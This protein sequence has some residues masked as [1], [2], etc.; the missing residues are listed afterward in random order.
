MMESIEF[1]TLENEALSVRILPGL[2]GKITSLRLKENDFELAAPN[3]GGKYRQPQEDYGKED[4]AAARDGDTGPDFSRYDASGLDDAFPNIDACVTQW[5]GR[6]YCYP[7]HGEI[8]SHPFTVCETPE[9]PLLSW[10]SSRFGY[11]YEKRFSLSG[12]SLFIRYRIENRSEAAFPWLWTFHG[13]MRYEEDM[14]LLLPEDFERYRCVADHPVMGAAGS[15]LEAV[16]GRYDFTRVPKAESHSAVKYY[17]EGRSHAGQCGL[18][19][20]SREVRCTLK[21]DANKLPYLGVWITAGG[22]RGDYN[23]ALEP[24]TGF[25]DDVP[26][27]IKNGTIR[28]LEPGGEFAFTLE[29]SLRKEKQ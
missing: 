22:Y 5:E 24:A 2:G 10:E 13:L 26:R 15:I 7:D 8:W 23:C 12:N 16:N 4:T 25:Y 14:R 9:G 6:T 20:P 11:L 28:V 18:W 19:Y 17:G 21:Y 29:I 27:T 3:T 1:L